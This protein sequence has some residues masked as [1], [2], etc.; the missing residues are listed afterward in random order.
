[1]DAEKLFLDYTS[2]FDKNTGRIRLKIL[3]SLKV[4]EVMD[5]LTKMLGLSEH[6]A[7]LA[8]ITAVFHDIGRFEQVTKY[9]TFND[10]ISEDHAAIACRVLTEKNFLSELPKN[11]QHMILKAIEN[12]NKYIIEDGLDSKTLLLANLIRDADKIDI[13]RVFATEDP[14][15]T[16]G[17]SADQVSKETISP[18]VY[19]RIMAH[20]Q[21]P[22]SIR[23]TGLDFW[24]G[25]LGFIYNL[26][27]K[28]SLHIIAK[29]KYYLRPFESVT[30]QNE[31]TKEQIPLILSEIGKYM[32]TSGC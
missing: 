31:R 1:M 11:E 27:Y 7:Y 17:E 2:G 30:F 10:Q 19:K 23:K 28:E 4:A 24:I 20:E 9:N 13:L 15:D 21:I 22:K 12:H 26:Y 29:D 8:H 32:K 6:D 16:M 3:H 14:V 25:F 18:E 5:R